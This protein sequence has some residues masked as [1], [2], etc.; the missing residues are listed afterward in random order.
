MIILELQDQPF[1]SW[2]SEQYKVAIV[3]IWVYIIVANHSVLNNQM[4]I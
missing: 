1:E 3:R 2:E 4:N